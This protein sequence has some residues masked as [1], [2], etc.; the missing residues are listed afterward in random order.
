M[1]HGTWSGSRIGWPTRP[2]RHFKTWSA[3]AAWLQVDAALVF[4]SSYQAQ[5]GVLESMFDSQ[6]HVFVD[7]RCHPG[8]GAGARLSDAK[9]FPFSANSHQKLGDQLDRS[10]SARFRCIVANGV[11]AIDGEVA[12]L[13]PLCELAERYDAAV[14]VEDEALPGDI[15]GVVTELLA[16]AERLERMADASRKLARPQAAAEIAQLF[17]QLGQG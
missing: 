5:T 11:S 13:Q 17:L 8:I 16:D 1:V 10:R 14:I 7:D 2:G 4:A 15:A 9:V 6:D 12:S 3:L